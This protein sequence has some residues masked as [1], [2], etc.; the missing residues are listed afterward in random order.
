MP[1]GGPAFI[2]GSGR[3]GSTALYRELSR[4]PGISWMSALMDRTPNRAHLNAA[5][6]R[7][8]QVPIL[9]GVVERY[10][11]PS[12]AYR[13]WDAASPAFR[14]ARRDLV[15]GDVT[16]PVAQRIRDRAEALVV[17]SRPQLLLKITGWPRISYLR[18]VFPSAKFVHV[19]RDGR[20]V[21]ASLL[22]VAWWDGW[23]GPHSWR[24]GPLSPDQEERWEASGRS[25]V[26]LAGLNWEIVVEAT[27]QAAAFLDAAEVLTVR[28]ED[29]CDDPA[30]TMRVVTDFLDLEW[31]A[32]FDRIEWTSRFQPSSSWRRRLT[33]DQLT[34][35]EACIGGALTRF[36]YD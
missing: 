17:P 7:A 31:P 13:W 24:F 11:R 32:S 1:Q 29:L 25:F 8:R 14:S 4:H 5:A 15:A 35:L 10:A 20:A 33:T 28:Y 6:V 23:L 34:E 22:H 2:I 30:S 9:G 18:D 12:E 19:L 16:P 3:C 26:A 21:A 36:G 27:A